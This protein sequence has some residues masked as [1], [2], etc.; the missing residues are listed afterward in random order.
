[1]LVESHYSKF[2]QM[3]LDYLSES[4]EELNRM[5]KKIDLEVKSKSLS[6]S[7]LTEFLTESNH[8]IVDHMRSKTMNLIGNLITNGLELSKLT[9]NMDKNL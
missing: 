7:Q 6:G 1:M 2:V 4:H 3:D 5:V 9:F 8:K